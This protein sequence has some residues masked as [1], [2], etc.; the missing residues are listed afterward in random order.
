MF[1]G[2]KLSFG[3]AILYLACNATASSG[4]QLGSSVLC[5]RAKAHA[6]IL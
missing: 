6:I 1:L 2:G 3:G 4:I 5:R